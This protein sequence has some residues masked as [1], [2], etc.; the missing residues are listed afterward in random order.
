MGKGNAK[1]QQRERPLKKKMA[2]ELKI[3]HI[4]KENPNKADDSENNQGD[5]QAPAKRKKKSQQCN[6][7][8]K[9]SAEIETAQ[10]QAAQ[11][12]KTLENIGSAGDK[13][14]AV[15][16]N[17]NDITCAENT[18]KERTWNANVQLTPVTNEQRTPVNYNVQRSPND[19]MQQT[20]I[21][22]VV[23]PTPNVQHGIT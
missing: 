6:K 13:P 11:F 18:Q 2:T 17:D 10:L 16:I 8:P 22:E 14:S 23:Q 1:E 9:W 19:N 20:P 4:E 21:T 3:I 7:Q 12:F 5:K 15:T